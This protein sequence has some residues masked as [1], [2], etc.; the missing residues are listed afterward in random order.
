MGFPLVFA[1]DDDDDDDDDGEGYG[2]HQLILQ[3]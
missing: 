3:G 2:N 1:I